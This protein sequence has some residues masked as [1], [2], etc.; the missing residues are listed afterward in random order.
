[1]SWLAVAEASDVAAAA[2]AHGPE[3]G[4]LPEIP[5]LVTLVARWAPPPIA[6]LLHTW[7][8]V[9]FA[10]VIVGIVGGL[11]TWGARALARI[12]SRA[13][14]VVEAIVQGLDGFV[15]GVLGPS[16][17]RR[18]LP[19]LG[20]LFLF[21]LSMNLAG[22]VPGFKSP[23]SKIT[24][25]GALAFCVFCY[26]QWTGLRRLG[27]LGYVDHF[28]G[29]P[30]DLMGWILAP[31]LLFIHAIGELVK[32][33]SLAARLFGNIMAEDTLLGVFVMLG[34]M[35]LGGLHLPIGIPLH[36]PFVL[37]ALIF[38]GVQAIVFT[39]LSTVY[40]SMVLP[41]EAHGPETE[42]STQTHHA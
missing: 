40:I 27:P 9:I 39:L 29:Q 21:I 25:T 26:V 20:T 41:H 1:M 5:N 7:E 6:H 19:F 15:G 32:P 28:L 30:R 16:E 2:G 22:L 8:D 23:T 12:P 38:S 42:P 31:L 4:H 10:F 3:V 34:T 24:M 17:G 14:T 36:L 37:L 35:L 18:Y 11:I 33:I 13:Q